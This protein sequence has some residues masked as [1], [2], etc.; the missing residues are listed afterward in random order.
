M[1]LANLSEAK[2]FFLEKYGGRVQETVKTEGSAICY[3]IERDNHLYYITFKRKWY[4]QFGRDLL[5]HHAVGCGLDASLMERAFAHNGTL[6]FIFENEGEY[7]IHSRD[8]RE[9][10]QANN[11][12]HF[13]KT[14][15]K[16]RKATVPAS[17]LAKVP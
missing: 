2:R 11:T 12:Y 7:R 1:K 15:D 8:F 14:G 9:F 3:I 17:I 13:L 10:V 6:V 5:G 4:I 16:A